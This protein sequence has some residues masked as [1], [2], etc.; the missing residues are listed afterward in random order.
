MSVIT[1]VQHCCGLPMLS[2]GMVKQAKH[3][4]SANIARWG[5]LLDS[6]DH[7]VVTCSSCGLSLMQEWAYLLDHAAVD[8]VREKVIHIS[9]LVNGL[10]ERL[11]LK[12]AAMKL[13]YHYPCH[14]KIQ[15]D[16]ESSVRML[17]TIDGI[18]VVPIDTH[19]CGIAGSWGMSA[20][21]YDLSAEIGRDLITKLTD[22]GADAGVTDC[23][24]CRLQMEHFSSLP[25]KHPI[26]IV[27]DLI[28]D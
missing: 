6:V 27:S 9:R 20:A 17:A 28:A 24:T 19:C 5:A 12:P 26:E 11:D 18:S 10:P 15:P 14:L 13:A 4:V 1:P 7:I 25:I 23:P 2:K 21:H 16:P 8:K 22:C 3:K